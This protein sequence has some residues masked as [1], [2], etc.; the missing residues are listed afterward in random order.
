MINCTP[1]NIQVKKTGYASIFTVFVSHKGD[2]FFTGQ[3]E[4]NMTFNIN[5][6]YYK[7]I[8]FVATATRSI[9]TA[10]GAAAVA[11]AGAFFGKILC[12]FLTA[13]KSA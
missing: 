12:N 10:L 5:R 13:S 7:S 2:Y 3:L 9:D 8:A 6:C 1:L 11:A 4:K